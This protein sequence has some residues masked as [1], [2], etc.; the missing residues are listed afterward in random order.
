MLAQ[1]PDGFA[2]EMVQREP[3]TVNHSTRI[4]RFRVCVGRLSDDS[5]NQIDDYLTIP[6]APYR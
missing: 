1:R 2:E 6:S 4:G 5:H 3:I